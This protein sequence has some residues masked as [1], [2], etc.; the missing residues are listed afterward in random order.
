MGAAPLEQKIYWQPQP[1]QLKFLRACGLSHPFDGGAPKKPVAR[2]IGYG[3]AAGGGKSDAMMGAAIIYALTYP[4]AKIGYFR[5]TFTQL[6]GAGGAIM[7]SLELLTGIAKYN[8]GKH[9]WKFPNGSIIKF[10]HLQRDE[11]V[12]NYQSQQFD[13]VFFDE[14]TQFSWFRVQYIISSRVRSVRGYP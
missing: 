8:A 9:V 6:E 12:A 2:I 11:E 4:K 14:A 13:C 1:R 10:C 3:G 7:R 5:C